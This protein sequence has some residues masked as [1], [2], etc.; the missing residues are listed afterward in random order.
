ML[1]VSLLGD[2]DRHE[3]AEWHPEHPTRLQAV[4]LGVH[5]ADVAD[6]TVVVE[7]RPATMTELGR[8]HPEMYLES[9]AQLCE[10]G[11]GELDPDT[12]VSRGSWDTARLAA[13]AGLAAVEALIRGA[14]DAAFVAGRPPGHHAR[15]AQG[16]GFCL[17]N[18]VA[19]VAAA[20][21]DQGERVAIVDWDAHH[22]NGT[23]EIFWDDPRVLYVSTHQSPL[24][25]GTGRI[26]ETGGPGAPGLTLNLP[27]PEGTTGDVLLRAFDEV[28]AP[29]V[30]AFAPTWVLVSAGFDA[31]RDD[32]MAGMGL[33]AGDF[34]HLVRRVAAWAPRTG[35]L[36][37]LLEGGYD[38]AALRH[39]VSAT[40]ATLVH[41]R[42]ST[43]TATS[44]GPGAVTVEA[45][46]RIRER[47]ANEGGPG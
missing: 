15:R 30:D 46:K 47:L 31:H 34:V 9:L 11:G 5:D 16:M 13:G 26:S 2:G 20:L 19:V 22:G 36:A 37:L 4:R 44:G 25:P 3:T 23:Q 39:S 45:A 7:P 32:P 29:V 35:R 21:A 18:N 14:G 17:L 6:A 42:V 40:L 43:E 10:V 41:G 27:F 8:V 24:F 28:V 38:L 33:S 12:I 1:V